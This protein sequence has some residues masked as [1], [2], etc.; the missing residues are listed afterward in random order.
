MPNLSGLVVAPQQ[1][2]RA[3]DLT[4]GVQI[5]GQVLQVPNTAQRLKGQARVRLCGV[6]D[7]DLMTSVQAHDQVHRGYG[8]GPILKAP[9]EVRRFDVAGLHKHLNGSRQEQD[10]SVRD[11][12]GSLKVQAV[13]DPYAALALARNLSRTGVGHPLLRAR[14]SAVLL[15]SRGPQ[16]GDEHEDQD[17]SVR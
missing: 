12:A 9:A 3:Q 13:E 14:D 17:P 5:H 16:R 4:T 8:L 6:R 10:F 2:A 7:P 15:E 1:G 11:L